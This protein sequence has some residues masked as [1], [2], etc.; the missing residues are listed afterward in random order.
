MLHDYK[1]LIHFTLITISHSFTFLLRVFL[2][3]SS[4]SH[5]GR[6]EG[7]EALSLSLQGR[8]IIIEWWLNTIIGAIKISATT[9]VPVGVLLAS[10][11]LTGVSARR[12]LRE[13]PSGRSV[14]VFG[15][16]RYHP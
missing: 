11:L 14:F 4:L 6:Q 12:S 3:P 7:N 1:Y 10:P 15:C 13:G 16:G 5:N 2:S 8:F 9:R